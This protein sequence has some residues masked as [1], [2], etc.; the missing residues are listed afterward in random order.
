MDK[1][2]STSIVDG[3]MYKVRYVQTFIALVK[4]NPAADQLKKQN[5]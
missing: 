1:G 2:W 3:E 4:Y 5:F